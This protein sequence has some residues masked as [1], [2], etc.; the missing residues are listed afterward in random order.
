MIESRCVLTGSPAT[1][2]AR[3]LRPDRDLGHGLIWTLFSN[4]FSSE[5]DFLYLVEHQRP[6]T[7]IVRSVRQPQPNGIW[8]IERSYPFR[9][10]LA[11]GLVLSFRATCVATVHTR[12]EGEPRTERERARGTTRQD[13]VLTAW[14]RLADLAT[15][16][17]ED[18][19]EVADAAA[20]A[21]L[22]RQALRHGFELLPRDPGAAGSLVDV[23]GYDRHRLPRGQGKHVRFGSVTYQGLLRVTDVDAFRLL[24]RR[25]LGTE[26]AFGFGLVQIAR[27]LTRGS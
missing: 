12:R 21:W 17:G 9:P 18:L 19:A 1:V 3:G 16:S 4:E 14:K 10:V 11:P 7:A 15:R 8:T 27:P 26:R 24:L 6:F 20:A 2:L 5:R 23:L 22:G 13:V 25:G